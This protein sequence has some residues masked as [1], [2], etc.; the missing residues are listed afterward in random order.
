MIQGLSANLNALKTYE[1]QLAATA[2][3]IANVNTP[4]YATSIYN[5]V[6]DYT[7]A[8]ETRQD[9]VELS[10][11]QQ[12]SGVDLGREMTNMIVEKRAFQY[13]VAA[14]KTQDEMLGTLID[15]KG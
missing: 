8:A 6:S 15:L 2:N 4:G 3:N 12:T 13:N 5:S 11:G 1:D 9:T 10:S 14:V 7:Q